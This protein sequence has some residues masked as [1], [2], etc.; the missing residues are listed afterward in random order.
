MRKAKAGFLCFLLM[1]L[2]TLPR[3][4]G[5]AEGDMTG[6]LFTAAVRPQ[7]PATPRPR[8]RG[9]PGDYGPGPPPSGSLG[10]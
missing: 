3:H 10:G 2:L 4:S 5:E 8:A 9:L 7:G 6:W 1:F